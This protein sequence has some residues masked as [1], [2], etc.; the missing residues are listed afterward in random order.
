MRKICRILLLSLAP[1]CA[2][3]DTAPR[4]N[5]SPPAPGASRPSAV[6]V[7]A[8]ATAET[9]FPYVTER[10]RQLA[11]A[12]FT[13]P[14]R[15]PAWLHGLDYDQ[16]RS[17]RFR[18]DAAVWRGASRFE[19]QL[20]HPGYLYTEAVRIHLVDQGRV[21]ELPFDSRL[22]RYDGNAAPAAAAVTSNLGY[23][24]FRVHYPLNSAA[25]KDEVAVFLGASY[26]RLV[27]PGHVYGLSSRGLAV[28]VGMPRPEEFPGFRE[29]WLVRPDPGAANLMLYALLDSPSVTGAY[30][31][32]LEPAGRT[33]VAVEARLFARRDVAKI[34]VAP[35]SSMFLFDQ[36]RRPY[37]EDY[38]GQVHDSDGALVEA[39]GG[40]WIW[41]PLNNGPGTQVTALAEGIVH[42]FGLF[43]RDREFANYL[44]V[45]ANYHRRPSEWVEVDPSGWGR[46]RV[47][48]LTF[49]TRNEFT[50]N[51]ALY[52]VPEHPF[53][54]GDERTYRYRL[55]M[56]DERHPDQAVG[57]VVRTRT[58]LDDLTRLRPAA[59]D[60]RRRV[61]VDF[62]GGELAELAG[63]EPVAV[64]DAA[65]GT[66]ADLV[67]QAL[68]DD[69]TWRA[70]FELAP[71]ADEPVDLRLHL[72]ADGRR[73]TE[74]WTYT[75]HP[76]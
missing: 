43:Q 76:P 5:Q 66:T 19:I 7:P 23:A 49:P 74:T 64:L 38:R 54:A 47:E 17:I 40:E 30:R 59:A 29:F 10:A 8:I 32:N 2:A 21:S 41:R 55:I 14:E 35:M 71:V 70:A 42:G 72:E 24:G 56:L 65:A 12:R 4:P 1:C 44:D 58:G 75:W 67:V 18:T 22:F 33:I 60:D 9:L 27:G 53:L 37:I 16:Y 13:A 52:W 25:I 20:F 45:E 3:G 73:L 48:L 62:S 31:F 39:A 63:R 15:L 36:N 46:G 50:D 68:P 57:R 69:G 6:D 11:G 34:G 61:I 26:F 51:V 28:D